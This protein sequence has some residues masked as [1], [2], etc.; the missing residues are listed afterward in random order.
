MNGG[1]LHAVEVTSAEAGR[2][3]D[4]YRWLGLTAVA[5]LIAHVR[6]ELEQGGLDDFEREEALELASDAEYGRL[7]PSDDHL[8]AALRRRLAQDQSAFAPT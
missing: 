4:G 6:R 8:V 7:L 5:E 2:A 1:V 3:E